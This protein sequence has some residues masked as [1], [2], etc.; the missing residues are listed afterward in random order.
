M[1]RRDELPGRGWRSLPS[2][3]GQA[4]RARPGVSLQRRNSW[5]L[6]QRPAWT[7]LPALQQA[8]RGTRKF[9]SSLRV[10]LAQRAIRGAEPK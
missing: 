2:V 5:A 1:R 7:P 8:V 4:V 10:S 3:P 6:S 9:R